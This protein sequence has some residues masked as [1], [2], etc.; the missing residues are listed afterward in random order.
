M[1]V[2]ETIEER[3]SVRAFTDEPVPDELVMETLRL[4][5]L[6]PSAGNLQARDFVVVRGAD[7]KAK[8]AK[9]SFGQEF[10]EKAPVVIVCC[11]NLARIRNYGIRGTDLYCLQDVAA[12]VENMLL[13]I[14]SQGYGACWVG[15]FD[16]TQVS[17]I[18]ELPESVRP[19]V[20]LPMGRPKDPLRRT[21]R[22]KL[23]TLVHSEKW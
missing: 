11:A 7:T 13:F 12:C 16:E 5:T 2:R 21:P 17:K 15:A 20:I 18:L 6:A 4:G 19:V 9:A 1:D 23:E 10:V 8:L 22:L 14:A 3:A